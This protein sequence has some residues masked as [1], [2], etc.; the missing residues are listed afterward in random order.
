MHERRWRRV[1]T[2]RCDQNRHSDNMIAFK[3]KQR[4]TRRLRIK[5]RVSFAVAWFYLS[6]SKLIRP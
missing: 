4:Y 1:T 6:I 2:Y 5:R 3:Y